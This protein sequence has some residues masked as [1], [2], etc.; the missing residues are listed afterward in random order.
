M[1]HSL[2]LFRLFL[3]FLEIIQLVDTFIIIFADDWIWTSDLW[4]R[5]RPLYQL[6]QSRCL[7]ISPSLFLRSISCQSPIK[8]RDSCFDHNPCKDKF[9]E[10]VFCCCPCQKFPRTTLNSFPLL[11]R[12]QFNKTLLI[13]K[14]RVFN[15]GIFKNGPFPASFILF[16]SFLVL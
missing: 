5:N 13:C 12:G 10:W 4:C 16:L 3:S 6:C 2:P 15:Y 1:G 11:T 7:F 9:L 14:L 8:L